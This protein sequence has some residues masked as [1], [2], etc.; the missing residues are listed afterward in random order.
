MTAASSKKICALHR[1]LGAKKKSNADPWYC[2]RV[3][4]TK[5]SYK[6]KIEKF[7]KFRDK[8]TSPIFAATEESNIKWQLILS[9]NDGNIV[10]LL[11]MTCSDQTRVKFNF[12]CY[13][14]KTNGEL[15]NCLGKW[16]GTGTSNGAFMFPRNVAI[17]ELQNPSRGLLHNDALILIC[18]MTVIIDILDS[19]PCDTTGLNNI[20]LKLQEGISQLLTS[21]KFSDVALKVSGKLFKAHKSILS[22]RSDVFAAMFDHDSMMENTTNQIVI[23]D[24]NHQVI[25]EMLTF[26]YTNKAPHIEEMAIDLL[27]CADKYALTY[28]KIMCEFVL[29]REIT[30]QNALAT[31][32]LAD[33]Y[34][35]A[36]LRAR[37]IHFVKAHLE[38]IMK[39]EEWPTMV[40]NYGP[41][42][43]EIEAYNGCI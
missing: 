5:F 11:K 39:S 23:K 1:S 3:H 33:R 43:E 29:Y 15:D 17:A 14:L 19:S 30:N 24:F 41:I 16:N 20:D 2:D 10:M 22:L 34:S 31:L 32:V 42:I 36:T 9:D 27:A 13:I 12:K 35:A 7:S 38:D 26:I 4:L 6:W 8:I 21:G 37:S 18:D 25:G 28:L 40:R